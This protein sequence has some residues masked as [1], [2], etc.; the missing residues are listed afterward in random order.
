M[1][2]CAFVGGL[3]DESR[4][5]R[6]FVG[7]AAVGLELMRRNVEGEAANEERAEQRAGRREAISVSSGKKAIVIVDWW[8][9][10]AMAWRGCDR[11]HGKSLGI[12][13]PSFATL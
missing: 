12:W 5:K 11:S 3:K 7:T 10:I 2:R 4:T 9:V 1:L 13:S 6:V 8:G